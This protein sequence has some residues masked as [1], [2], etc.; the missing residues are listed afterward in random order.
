MFNVRATRK[1]LK[2]LG[3]KPAERPHAPTTALGDWYANLLYVGRKQLVLCTN[4]KSLL[5]VV[6]PA[7]GL[8]E[9][10]HLGLCEAVRRLLLRIDIPESKVAGELAEMREFSLART[11]N[12]TV[13][14]SMNDL[15]F[16]VEV[17]LG[18]GPATS[19]DELALELS[20]VPCGPLS[21]AHPAEV[22][23]TLLGTGDAAAS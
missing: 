17:R 5:S 1:L 21:Y 6:L 16:Q 19:L 3:T 11:D 22:T 18:S 9:G 15:A 8:K 14:G 10:L 20:D 7:R 23:R 12:R 13:L 2:R 4:D